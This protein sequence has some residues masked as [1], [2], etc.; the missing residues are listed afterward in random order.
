MF[1]SRVSGRQRAELDSPAGELTSLGFV[2]DPSFLDGIGRCV[3]LSQP[4]K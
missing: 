1:T 2:V 3:A 4:G